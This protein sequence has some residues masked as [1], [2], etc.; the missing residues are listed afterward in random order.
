M[1]PLIQHR[2]PILDG[3]R[4]VSILLVL[5][6]HMLPLGPKVLRLNETTGPMG[7][8]LFFGLSGFLITRQLLGNDNVREFLIRRCARILP[9]AYAYILIVFGIFSF[10]PNRLFWTATFVENYF[11]S[12]LNGYNSHFWS[13]CVEMQFYAFI[14]IVVATIGKRGLWIVIP[15]CVT[16]TAWRM[17]N[18]A[19]VDIAT[20]LRADEILAGACVGLL[21]AEDRELPHS[22]LL[23]PAVA[24]AWIIASSPFS[25]P[26]QYLRPY[27]SAVLIFAMLGQEK[28]RIGVL[29]TSKIMRYIAATSYALYVIHHGL[30]Q[31]W[32]NEGSFFERYLFKRPI[33]FALTFLLAHVSTFYWERHWINGAKNWIRRGK[34]TS[35]TT[36][37]EAI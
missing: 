17:A 8:S 33:S 21:Y 2:F 13:L 15:A 22:R 3:L 36:V 35:V 9:L 14:A 29:L 4:A 1:L 12:H 18:G 31:G 7:M 10:D 25:G 5:A 16:I 37:S 11:P 20:H 6:T 23:L 32:W 30:I 28:T 34:R 24:L 19:Y 26:L 27:T